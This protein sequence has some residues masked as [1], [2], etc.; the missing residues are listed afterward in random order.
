MY[1]NVLECIYQHCNWISPSLSHCNVFA[2]HIHLYIFFHY[3]QWLPSQHAIPL[4]SFFSI[5]IDPFQLSCN[6]SLLFTSIH[7]PTFHIP[8]R[9]WFRG[10]L[11]SPSKYLINYIPRK[12]IYNMWNVGLCVQRTVTIGISPVGHTN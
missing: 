6:L 7:H 5:P 3:I 4:H 8:C 2:M 12:S 9:H 11:R 1:F 10:A